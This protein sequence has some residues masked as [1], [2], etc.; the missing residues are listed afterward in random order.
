[1]DKA[2]ASGLGNLLAVLRNRKLEFQ[3]DYTIVAVGVVVVMAAGL[4]I[5][6]LM[7]SGD[8]TGKSGT[9][10]AVAGS[11]KAAN[12]PTAEREAAPVEVKK[13][14][15][16]KTEPTVDL[17]GLVLGKDGRPV[18]SAKAKENAAPAKPPEKKPEKEEV[19]AK[20]K[21]FDA[22]KEPALGKNVSIAVKS[23]SYGRGRRSDAVAFVLTITN[24]TKQRR[25]R[26]QW[27]ALKQ[28]PRESMMVDSVEP[29][30]TYRFLGATVDDRAID[31]EQS[32]ELTLYFEKPIA[33]AKYVHLQL[34][35]AVFDETEPVK[36]EIPVEM[37][38]AASENKEQTRPP[39]DQT[40]VDP[41][42]RPPPP[43]DQ[44]GAGEKGLPA[45]DA[46]TGP[47]APANADPAPRGR[48]RGGR[49][50]QVAQAH[51]RR[52]A[53]VIEP[54]ISDFDTD[55]AMAEL[56]GKHSAKRNPDR[57]GSRDVD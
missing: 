33:A 23:A 27:D 20:D 55:P 16:K 21:W 28:V 48:P 6:T 36:L 47:D 45:G 26:C 1:M 29:P 54:R 53:A 5:Y 39:A 12:D 38:Q 31:P 11:E 56:Y 57:N 49:G 34:P 3:V 42:D 35:G 43:L 52:P 24:N 30:N 14:P 41:D 32:G 4:F 15:E 17:M 2:S 37:I 10:V 44:P 7:P 51:G 22:S 18:G 13:A 19:V 40:P 8:T 9:A 25:L 50:A 46:T